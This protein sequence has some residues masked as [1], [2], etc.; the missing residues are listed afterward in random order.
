MT[1]NI[2][3]LSAAHRVGSPAADDQDPAAT[4]IKLIAD[5]LGTQSWTL[6]PTMRIIEDLGADSLDYVE[7]I[8]TVEE[9]FHIALPADSLPS[10]RTLGDLV[11][12]VVS[13]QQYR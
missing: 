8:M 3:P 12:F 10:I 7:L 9:R 4:V 6:T 11:S 5:H 13:S 2:R 1:T